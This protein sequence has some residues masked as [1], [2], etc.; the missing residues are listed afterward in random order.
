MVIRVLAMLI[1]GRDSRARFFVMGVC[2]L[3]VA[4]L[5]ILVLERMRGGMWGG[6]GCEGYVYEGMGGVMG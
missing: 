5:L 3:R 2:R 1:V 6:G 4:G